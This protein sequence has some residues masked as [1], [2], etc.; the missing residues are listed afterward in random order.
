MSTR[1]S[2]SPTAS[3]TTLCRTHNVPRIPLEMPFAQ[4][5]GVVLSYC[6]KCEEEKMIAEAEREAARLQRRVLRGVPPHY[7]GADLRQFDAAAVAPA[8]K[9]AENPAGFLFIGG[10]V[11]TG[12]TH[13][14]CA[15]QK[16]LNAD[17]R[18][19]ALVFSSEM[20][21]LLHRSFSKNKD[22][23]LVEDEVVDKYASKR[24]GDIAIFDDVGVHKVSDYTT[25]AWFKI[26]DR[27]YRNDSPTMITTNLTPKELAAAVGDHNSSRIMSGAWVEFKGEDRRLKKHWTEKFD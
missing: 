5:H 23:G 18:K 21:L 25:E 10:S 17:G 11:G 7:H 24:G 14:A 4:K 8:L 9:W 13:L 22:G 20:F 27:R 26:I 12:K 15:V 16:K 19:S 1:E 6:P 2:P 3:T